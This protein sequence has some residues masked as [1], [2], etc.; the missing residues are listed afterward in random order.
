MGDM[1][2]RFDRGIG[3]LRA[4]AGTEEPAV[5]HGYDD[6]APGLGRLTVEFPYGDV[7]HRSDLDLRE[8]QLA[9]IGALTAL[10]HALPQLKFHVNGALNIGIGRREIVEAIMHLVSYTGFPAVLNAIGAAREVFEA[11]DDD[12]PGFADAEAEPEGT[13]YD[14]GWKALAEIDGHAGE[15]V[16][17]SLEP[18]APDL[19]RYIIE[20]AFGDVYVRKGLDLRSREIVTVAACTALGSAL[21]QLKVHI[22]GLLNVGGTREEVVETI[23]QMAVYAGFPAALNAM[24]AAREVFEARG[25]LDG[26]EP[27]S[28]G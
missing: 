28:A 12:E 20:F 16:I 25:L 8:R 3:I 1:E 9:T 5:V 15:A 7:Y 14:R 21:P 17:A 6:I 4:L 26:A 18:I 27:E 10:G 2:N 24:N 22:H 19:G 11:R 13:R 23:I